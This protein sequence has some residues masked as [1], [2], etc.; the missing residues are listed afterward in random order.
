MSGVPQPAR[1]RA[2]AMSGAPLFSWDGRRVVVTGARGGL[3]ARLVARLAEAGAR[4]APVSRGTSWDPAAHEIAFLVAGSGLLQSSAA[5][6]LPA[7]E[8]MF[9]LNVLDAIR[10]AQAALAAGARHVHVVGS[11][12]GVVSSP[13]LALYSAT[14]YALRGWAYGSARELPGRVSI[15]YPNGMRTGF[16]AALA[17]EPALLAHYGAA[18][19]GAAAGYDDPDDVA[20]GILE[21]I[22]WGAREIIPTPFALAWF[23]KNEEDVRR[24]WHPGLRQP[25]VARFD[26]WEAV[27]AHW[28]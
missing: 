15:S 10:D 5:P 12:Q 16:F 2:D 14:K 25:S 19:D 7:A 18:V 21:G 3:G 4:V 27:G 13:H 1:K 6:L 17:G 11:I 22:G 20:A 8:E 9:R 28:A 23:R 24:M 26:W